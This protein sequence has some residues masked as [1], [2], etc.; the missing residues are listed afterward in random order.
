MNKYHEELKELSK[1][2][3]KYPV[4]YGCGKCDECDDMY[5]K[6]VEILR[7]ID[8]ERTH[9]DSRIVDLIKLCKEGDTI[10]W[11]E[12]NGKVYK[13]KLEKLYPK[14]WKPKTSKGEK[15]NGK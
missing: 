15:A 7:K 4:G 5:K 8:K 12:A 14:N 10:V 3:H 9:Q 6:F 2:L 11:D 1:K 13:I